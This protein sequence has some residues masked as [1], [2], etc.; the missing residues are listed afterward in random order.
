MLQP[1]PIYLPI[2]AAAPVFSSFL[3][4]VMLPMNGPERRQTPRTTV[5]KFVYINI[6]PSNGGNVLN[7]SEGGICFHSI[8][9][10]QM[11][12]TITVWFSEHNRRIKIEGELAWMDEARKTGGVRFT[13]LPAE[14]REPIRNWIA[15]PVITPAADEVSARLLPPWR[16]FAGASARPAETNTAPPVSRM[17][18]AILPKIRVPQ[19]LRGFSG[20]LATG[21]LVSVVVTAVFLFHGYRRQ[22]GEALIQWGERL[23]ARSQAQMQ[24][25]SPEP[26]LPA[27]QPVLPARRTV[28]P[29]TEAIMVQPP[30]ELSPP[31]VVHPAESQQAKVEPAHPPRPQPPESSPARRTTASAIVAVAPVP[32]H[33]PAV[34]PAPKTSVAPAI[35]AMSSTRSPISLP[36][37]AVSPS[38]N[39]VSPRPRSIPQLQPESHPAGQPEHPSDQVAGSI[40]GIYLEVAKFKDTLGAESARNRLI[41]LGF[42]ATVIQK[43]RLWMNSYFVV[44]GPYGDDKAEAARKNLASHGFKTRAFERGS[45][46]LTIYGGC[47]TM[48]RLLRSGPTPRVFDVPVAD[49]MISWESY[50]ARAI[51]KFVQDNYVI[52]TADG[53]WVSRGLRFE[54]DAFVY[55]KNEDG[56]QT[57]VEIQFAGMNQALVFDQSS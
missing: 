3:Y 18:A 37:P 1:R 4:S 29:S 23:A 14:A 8:A 52:A 46:T 32:V 43:G 44:V 40:P 17:L 21:L 55:R 10:V 30:H 35:T 19:R 42:H 26:Q 49:C 6:E 54:R 47:D 34:S 48:S 13:S 24:Q 5:E 56:S 36:S 41:Q 51:V 45:R 38:S 7:V 57:L 50:S 31:S 53:K 9:P 33:A 12:R 39:V 27:Q 22:F 15:P 25:A 20:G 16:A 11:D 2:A 28:S